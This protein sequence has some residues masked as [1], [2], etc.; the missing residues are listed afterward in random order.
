MKDVRYHTVAFSGGVDSSLVA[1]LLHMV[2]QEQPLLQTRAVLGVSAAVP[3]EQRQLAETIA[4]FIGID[5]TTT[6]THE[7]RDTVYIE[8]NGQACLA[9]K[10]NLYDTLKAI[11]S[12]SMVS[13]S[14]DQH[15]QK[16]HHTLYNGTNLDDTKDP[17]RL[18]LIAANQFN[19]QSPLFHTSKAYVRRAAQHLGLPNWNYAASPC[20]RSRLA[21]GVHATQEHL[22]TIEK[23]EQ[24][25]RH[26]LQVPATTNLRVRL[27]IGQKACLEIDD[28]LVERAEAT[29]Q[30]HRDRWDAIFFNELG[31]RSFSVRPFK[32]GSVA[33]R[34]ATNS[35]STN[36]V[37]E[38]VAVAS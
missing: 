25:V 20:L 11:H 18:G 30:T 8:N 31:F 14:S 38:Q 26:E 22:Q 1:M 34:D 12:N 27:L 15:N 6:P 13:L 19:V 29:Y 24:F 16:Q 5:F 10:T 35:A 9:C 37:V 28:E 7:G 36:V 23:A 4:R 32:S 17:T 2:G 33:R 3:D 21:L